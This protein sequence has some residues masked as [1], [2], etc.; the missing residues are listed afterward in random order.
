VGAIAPQFASEG[1]VL[2]RCEHGVELFEVGA[3]GGLEFFDFR[4]AGCVFFL[5][6]QA[7]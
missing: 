6:A 4:D 5:V 7:G 3:M 1:A 2:K